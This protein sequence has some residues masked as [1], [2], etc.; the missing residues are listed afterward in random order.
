MDARLGPGAVISLCTSRKTPEAWVFNLELQGQ[1][2]S[3]KSHQKS[4]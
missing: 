2:E 1:A 4:P 3:S